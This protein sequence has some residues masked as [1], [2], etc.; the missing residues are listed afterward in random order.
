MYITRYIV[1]LVVLFFSCDDERNTTAPP[2]K[3]VVSWV[4]T[5]GG[6]KND[7]AKSVIKTQDGGYAV[8]GHTQSNDGDISDKPDESFDYW[9]LK[10][11][12]TDQLEWSKTYGGS[13]D[14]RGTTIVQTQEGGYV[15]IGYSQSADQDVT[16]NAG[17]Y[18]FWVAKL[19][20]NGEV[21]WQKSFGYIGSDKG[22]AI[23]Q[24]QDGGFFLTGSLD[25][26]ASGGAGNSRMYSGGAENSK[27][28][29]G[30]DYWGIKL[31]SNG[32]T[33]WTKYFGGNLNDSPKDAIETQDGGFLIIGASDSIDVDISG[34]IETYDYWV[35]KINAEGTLIW[36]QSY[37]GTQIDEAHSIVAAADGNY[38]II[39]DTRSDD[40]NVSE[41]NGAADI[42]LIKINPNGDLIWEKS[43]GGSSF[44]GGRSIT[45]T[46][47]NGFIIA[48]SSRS[49]NGIL[50]N[51]NGQ[52]D[53]LV[54][55]LD[56]N[57]NILWQKTIGGSNIDVFY[58][59]VALENTSVIAVG[60]TS[61]EDFDILENKGFT[62]ILIT[63]IT[64]E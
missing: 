26:T 5:Y 46:S 24:T 20:E 4:K 15:L 28:H 11:N 56:Q 6:S 55:R 13:L 16:Q 54:I 21:T 45:K 23:L 48:G 31:T 64:Q 25:V 53:A 63:K 34:N 59:V 22:I 52:N 19:T 42:W 51:N 7:L 60:E 1:V 62:D 27:M 33:Q 2:S 47:D 3:G 30:G 50:T 35:V 29:S 18:D 14:D 40:V 57:C 44:D 61:S 39:G 8:L 36:E 38:I 58:D 41:N 17:S 37:G 32:D 9:M 10:F 49:E 43:F 12:A